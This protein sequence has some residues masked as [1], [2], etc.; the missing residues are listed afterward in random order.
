MSLCF[1]SNLRNLLYLIRL[2]IECFNFFSNRTRF[3]L[4]KTAKRQGLK[5]CRLI[6]CYH[7][8]ILWTCSGRPLRPLR[9]GVVQNDIFLLLMRRPASV[10]CKECYID[11]HAKEENS[12]LLLLAA[13][14]G[15]QNLVLVF[16][17]P[18]FFILCDQTD[19]DS[20][21]Y[22]GAP[23]AT[24][25]MNFIMIVAKSDL[26]TGR[27]RQSAGPADFLPIEKQLKGNKDC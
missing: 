9:E 23:V 18:H 27:S 13:C 15:E 24:V 14:V 8:P 22:D 17:K 3:V 7:Q 25:Q 6:E 20:V 4:L 21:F 12:A 5:P 11:E 1:Y 2:F 10:I 26:I 19:L 16:L